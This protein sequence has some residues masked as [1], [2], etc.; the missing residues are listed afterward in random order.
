MVLYIGIVG[1][2]L[3]VYGIG[4]LFVIRWVCIVFG[5]N[6]FIRGKVVGK[7]RFGDSFYMVN[8]C[9]YF[10]GYFLSRG[11]CNVSCFL[12]LDWVLLV[13]CFIFVKKL[14]FWRGRVLFI[15]VLGVYYC[16][17]WR[18]EGKEEKEKK[19]KKLIC[20]NEEWIWLDLFVG[21]NL[22]FLIMLKLYYILFKKKFF[23]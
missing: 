8:V 11:V 9:G 17:L 10:V 20:E 6:S 1:N 13:D 15:C 21:V 16:G 7:Y 22:R 12:C 3:I 18:M 4:E 5:V 19:K 23:M 2:G 14:W